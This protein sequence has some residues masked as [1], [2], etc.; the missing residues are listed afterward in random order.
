MKDFLAHC[1]EKENGKHVRGL[2][3]SFVNTRCEKF[4][5]TYVSEGL[6]VTFKSHGLATSASITC[7]HNTQ[8]FRH[9]TCI[10]PKSPVKE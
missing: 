6:D 8:R 4:K 3:K 2:W 9:L 7:Q 10:R 1:D 5:P